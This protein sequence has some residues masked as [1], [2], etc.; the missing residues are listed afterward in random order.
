MTPTPDPSAKA[1]SANPSSSA[2]SPVMDDAEGIV[3]DHSVHVGNPGDGGLLVPAVDR[4]IA[5]FAKAPRAVTA[6]RGYHTTSI[7][8]DLTELGVTTI[9]IPRTGKPSARPPRARAAP[10]L[11][12]A[13]QVAHRQRGPHQPPQASLRLGSHPASTASTAPRPGAAGES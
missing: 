8:G 13:D 12:Q 1:G 4:A 6:D 2:T 3:V 5:R 10:Q 7:E 11:P 9:V